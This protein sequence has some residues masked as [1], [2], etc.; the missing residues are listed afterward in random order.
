MRLILKRWIFLFLV[1]ILCGKYISCC[2]MENKNEHEQQLNA[3]KRQ[4]EALKLL[5]D[6]LHY[7][8]QLLEIEELDLNDKI[9]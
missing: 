7:Q 3:L 8:Q 6:K 2:E 4:E 5:I 9:Q 1:S